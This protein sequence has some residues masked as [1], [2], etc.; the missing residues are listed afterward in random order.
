MFFPSAKNNYWLRKNGPSPGAK[1]G[2]IF[3]GRTPPTLSLFNGPESFGL[4]KNGSEEVACDDI[5][6][7]LVSLLRSFDSG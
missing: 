3:T 6:E 5:L 2:D 7:Q 1:L 4:S